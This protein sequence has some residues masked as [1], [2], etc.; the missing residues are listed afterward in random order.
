MKFKH[1]KSNKNYASLI[2]DRNKSRLINNNYKFIIS[3][4][5]NY[6]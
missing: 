2:V 4:I 5:K 1:F 6:S 3:K